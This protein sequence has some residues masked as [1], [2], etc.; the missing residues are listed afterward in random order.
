M[1]RQRVDFCGTGGDK[2]G[3][4]IMENC[5]GCHGAGGRS[6]VALAHKLEL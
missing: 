4:L 1:L 3:A 6:D 2:T 5:V